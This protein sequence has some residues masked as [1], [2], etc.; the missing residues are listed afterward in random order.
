VSSKSAGTKGLAERYAAALYGLA[1]ERKALDEVAGD[2][3]SVQ[4]M[5]TE[6]EDFRRLVASPILSREDQQK[7]L[8][9]I[10]AKAGLSEATANF[11]GLVAG[12]RRLFALDD[13][14]AAYL[15]R[16]AAARGEVS[17]QVVSAKTLTENQSSALQAAL[18]KVVG[19]EVAVEAKIDPTI[20]GGLI[21]KIGS[22][23]VDSSVRSKLQRLQLAMKGV[24]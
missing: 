5:L 7:G 6:S 9:A 16:L 10:A 8:A 14:I 24:G 3:R 18:K 17:A 11:L 1:E 4:A 15:A 20:L 23:M 2:L 13:M 19:K 21:V 12:N 22:R